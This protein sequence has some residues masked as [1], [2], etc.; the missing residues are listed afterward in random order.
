M[1]KKLPEVEKAQWVEQAKEEHK[2]ALAQ[3]KK[4]SEGSYSDMPA[5]HQRCSLSSSF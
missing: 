1:F 5:D 2:A 3:W 4:G